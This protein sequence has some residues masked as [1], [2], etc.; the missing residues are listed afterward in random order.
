VRPN[1]VNLFEKTEAFERRR[2]ADTT[3]WRD[4]NETI[5]RTPVDVRLVLGRDEDER[6]A[7]LRAVQ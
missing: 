2:D 3:V 1:E 4:N 6:A 7:A 5:S